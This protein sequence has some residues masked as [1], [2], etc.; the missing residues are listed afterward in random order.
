MMPDKKRPKVD[1]GAANK[2]AKGEK[3][4]EVGKDKLL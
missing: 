2:R 1:S 3:K 4:E